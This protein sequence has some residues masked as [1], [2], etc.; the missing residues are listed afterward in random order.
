MFLLLRL[1]FNRLKR[2][3]ISVLLREY[4]FWPSLFLMLMEGNLQYFIYLLM[5]DISSLVSNRFSA[6]IIYV[7]TLGVAFLIIVF[8]IWIFFYVKRAFGRLVKY[9]LTNS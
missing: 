7:L 9:F 6:K 8:S 2:F 3:E 5:F 1:C 4:S